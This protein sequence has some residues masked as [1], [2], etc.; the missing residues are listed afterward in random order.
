MKSLNLYL[1]EKGYSDY[2]VSITNL[3]NKR[4]YDTMMKSG[5]LKKI[6]FI[7]RSIPN[8]IDELYASPKEYSSKG[9]LTTTVQ[10]RTSLS[11]YWKNAIDKIF[12]GENKNSVI[13]LND[14]NDQVDEIE[15]E[16]E[17]RGKIKTFHVMHKQKTQPDIDVTSDIVFVD[18][19]PTIESLVAA[20]EDLVNDILTLKPINA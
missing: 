3:L 15:F 7:K 5:N 1:K 9:T 8:T 4:V 17:F 20:S 13:E 18:N 10:S 12:V 11:D 2:L 6:D 14:G 16:L 19:Q